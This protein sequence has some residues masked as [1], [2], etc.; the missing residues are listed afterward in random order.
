MSAVYNDGSGKELIIEM[1]WKVSA[2]CIAVLLQNGSAKGKQTALES[3]YLMA[4]AADR[5]VAAEKALR[6]V[7]S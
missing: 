5:A 7:K 3:L 4:E 1:S 2:G 6:E